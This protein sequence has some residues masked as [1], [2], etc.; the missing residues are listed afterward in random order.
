MRF[1]NDLFWSWH[2]TYMNSHNPLSSTL[3]PIP[4]FHMRKPNFWGTHSVR[5]G[6]WMHLCLIPKNWVLTI[7]VLPW[8]SHLFCR[9][10]FD[11]F[12]SI[13]FPSVCLS[14]VHT[15]PHAC[16]HANHN[17]QPQ[18]VA[19]LLRPDAWCRGRVNI[20]IKNSSLPDAMCLSCPLWIL[21]L[22][23]VILSDGPLQTLWTLLT[24]APQGSETCWSCCP[25]LIAS[26]GDSLPL[27]HLQALNHSWSF[28]FIRDVSYL[29]WC[30][31]TLNHL[32]LGVKLRFLT[33]DG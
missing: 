2:I 25:G 12:H 22:Q 32:S 4:I 30:Q 3:V 11:W 26:P 23:T 9:C 21:W 13:L 10:L 29:G 18:I 19:W 5:A 16:I 20:W 33:F 1:I 28:Y 6:I 27:E 17:K 31:S 14:L 15:Q 7:T 8:P 24:F